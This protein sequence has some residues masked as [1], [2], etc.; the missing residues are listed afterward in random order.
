MKAIGVY[1]QGPLRI[2][3]GKSRS[4]NT[5][6]K[7]KSQLIRW[8]S[9]LRQ[10]RMTYWIFWG[11][12]NKLMERWISLTT[13]AI[14]RS[15]K[16]KSIKFT[17][18]SRQKPQIWRSRTMQ[19]NIAVLCPLSAMKSLRIA[20]RRVCCMRANSDNMQQISG[21]G[22]RSPNFEHDKP[23]QTFIIWR[24]S[25]NYSQRINIHHHRELTSSPLI[26]FFRGEWFGRTHACWH[27]GIDLGYALRDPGYSQISDCRQSNN[28][29]HVFS[30]FGFLIVRTLVSISCNRGIR[31]LA[32]S[33][34]CHQCIG[35]WFARRQGVS[36]SFSFWTLWQGS[37]RFCNRTHRI[38]LTLGSPWAYCRSNPQ[39][40]C[41]AVSPNYN[42]CAQ[43]AI[44]STDLWWDQ[45]W[46]NWQ[47]WDHRQ[48][49]WCKDYHHGLSL[50]WE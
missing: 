39:V 28:F 22:R 43:R 7:N 23:N 36:I 33:H 34:D 45:F 42:R 17:I 4:K 31:I 47:F 32:I 50:Q 44:G 9:Y 14:Y 6:P 27:H 2:G 35:Y 24:S 40:H 18:R 11:R 5:W 15:W 29:I 25:Y 49:R 1:W 48:H 46:T 37:A 26:F 21:R 12:R 30:F 38:T 10:Y 3:E 41:K 20:V 13:K 19:P 16:N 8:I